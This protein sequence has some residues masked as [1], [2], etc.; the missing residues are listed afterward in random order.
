MDSLQ[1]TA[2]HVAAL[3]SLRKLCSNQIIHAQL[4]TF[5]FEG[6]E[7]EDDS[8]RSIFN[9]LLTRKNLK[10]HVI[11]L[12]KA[13]KNLPSER[14]ILS[15]DSRDKIYMHI[16]DS[17]KKV[18]AETVEL[19]VALG[20]DVWLQIV[21]LLNTSKEGQ[22]GIT[23]LLQNLAISDEV[24]CTVSHL[25][26]ILCENLQDHNISK[27]LASIV[28]AQ[29]K[30]RTNEHGMILRT[31]D[32]LLERCAV[33][34]LT[35]TLMLQ[36]VTIIEAESMFEYYKNNME[37]FT[38]LTKCLVA[39]FNKF[40]A[41]VTLCN[42]I[43]SLAKLSTMF[44]EHVLG[45]IRDLFCYHC[46]TF[47]RTYER[48]GME[49]RHADEYIQP[50]TKLSNILEYRA[51]NILSESMF[52]TLNPILQIL[53]NELPAN[54]SLLA[55]RF[56]TNFMKHVWARLVLN[57]PVPMNSTS[58][59]NALV[60]V[61][62][63]LF[64]VVTKPVNLNEGFYVIRS[65]LDIL[66][67]IQPTMKER[68]AHKIFKKVS[69]DLSK[70][71]VKQLGAYIAK[72]VYGLEKSDDQAEVQ[73]REMILLGWISFCKNY[74]K[75]PSLTASE[76]VVANYRASDPFRGHMD[77]LLEHMLTQKNCLEQTVSIV[78]YQFSNKR[79][80]TGF[81]SFYQALDEFLTRH[82]EDTKKRSTTKLGIASAILAKLPTH[83]MGLRDNN[84]ENRLDVLDLVKIVVKSVDP[85]LKAGL[86]T[87]FPTAL[88][89]IGLSDE[90]VEYLQA[91]KAS[92]RV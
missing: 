3:K 32:H 21:R 18:V 61:T 69:F 48:C 76:K 41:H 25:L 49:E 71:R 8:F 34:E 30:L 55:I 23:T 15:D 92:L 33:D 10:M 75:L 11:Q 68:Y 27:R 77:L 29:M 44:P 43:S 37:K 73:K 6:T 78:V 59:K 70:E 5:F 58:I 47:L 53:C 1:S 12:M 63:N 89:T 87:E 40:D 80:P 28:V 39:A 35:F 52:T 57:K 14:D 16:F 62:E 2:L 65:L 67:M 85:S 86:L 46:K 50:I 88:D 74:S 4:E 64:E 19:M 38:A 45:N 20:D 79:D 13:I 66:V 82:I 56:Y 31:L 36:L 72:A 7:D 54:A 26:K 83:I 51:W 17:N 60:M 22:E 42:I 91:F 9:E 90:E 81:R 84:D 24:N